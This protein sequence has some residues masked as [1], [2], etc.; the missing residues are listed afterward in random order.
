[1]AKE[2]G[3]KKHATWLKQAGGAQPVRTEGRTDQG[4]RRRR[5]GAAG[6]RI[7]AQRRARQPELSRDHSAPRLL[8]TRP[9]CDARVGA[10]VRV[11][12]GRRRRLSAAAKASKERFDLFLRENKGVPGIDFLRGAV[13]YVRDQ[14]GLLGGRLPVRNVRGHSR[15]ELSGA[16]PH[17]QAVGADRRRSICAAR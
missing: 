9:V 6:E 13:S 10:L 14:L 12:A 15:V 3:D 7:D 11:H 4:G 16:G 1:M 5:G 17:A 8:A 2:K